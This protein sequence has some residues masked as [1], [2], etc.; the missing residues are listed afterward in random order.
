[1]WL[2]F[3]TNELANFVSNHTGWTGEHQRHGWRCLAPATSNLL[4]SLLALPWPFLLSL[5]PCRCQYSWPSHCLSLSLP[6]FALLCEHHI[7]YYQLTLVVPLE[8]IQSPCLRSW[9]YAAR[10]ELP[11]SIDSIQCRCLEIAFANSANLSDTYIDYSRRP[12]N[13]IANA[14]QRRKRITSS[15]GNSS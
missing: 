7:P 6:L 13:A 4:A 11:S 12:F 9:I 2:K 15:C 8:Y 5:P 1:L 10:V 14:H 3:G